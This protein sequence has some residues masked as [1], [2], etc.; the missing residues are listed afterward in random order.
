[1]GELGD[2]LRILRIRGLSPN[3]PFKI[4][5]IPGGI[6]TLVMVREVERKGVLQRQ[7]QEVTIAAGKTTTVNVRF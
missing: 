1:M 6:Y 2:C 7:E 5:N 3:S 4:E